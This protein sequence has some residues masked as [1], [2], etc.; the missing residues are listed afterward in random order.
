[1]FRQIEFF[2]RPFEAECSDIVSQHCRGFAI[3]LLE[4]RVGFAQCL[5]HPHRLRALA[6][7]YEADSLLHKGLDIFEMPWK[8]NGKSSKT[9]TTLST[10][11]PRLIPRQ[12]LQASPEIPH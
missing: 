7:K 12:T 5:P 2:C 6:G 4:M 3:D 8:V 9:A 11:R 10:L 1:M